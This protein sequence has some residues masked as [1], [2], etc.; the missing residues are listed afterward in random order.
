MKFK[1]IMDI[2]NHQDTI[3]MR[4]G[5]YNVAVN[6]KIGKYVKDMGEVFA[7]G[8]LKNNDISDI[9]DKLPIEVYNVQKVC[10]ILGI[11]RM[12]VRWAL[13]HQDYSKVP[14]PMYVNETKRGNTYFWIPEQFKQEK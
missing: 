3:I 12:A 11:T 2:L 8:E 10:E 14:K 5:G 4:Q 6:T 7:V 1:E 13:D 9:K